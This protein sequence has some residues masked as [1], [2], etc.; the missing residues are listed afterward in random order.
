MKQ[1]SALSSKSSKTVVKISP[2]GRPPVRYTA[3]EIA[4]PEGWIAVRAKW[5]HG[6]VDLGLVR[7]QPGDYLDEYFSLDEPMN[8]FAIFRE[9]GSFGGWY[10][11]VTHPTE[12]ADGEIHWHDLYVDVLVDP[13]YGQVDVLDED[14]LEDAGL[15]N[16]EPALYK[17]ILDARDEILRRIEARE[18][19]FSEVP[20]RS[21]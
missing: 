7:F 19:P 14:E 3:D 18:Y 13:T 8:A 6:S 2:E 5:V 15:V 11:N 4:S 16:S 17:M 12:I 9:D 10:C 20:A 21:P 1:I